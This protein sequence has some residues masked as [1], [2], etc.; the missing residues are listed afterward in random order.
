MIHPLETER[1]RLLPWGTDDWRELQ[2]IA[3]DREV[4]RYISNGQPW[5]DERIRELVDRQIA[6]FAQRG[7]CLWRLLHKAGGQMVGFCGLQPLAGTGE[8]EIG[9]WLGRAWWA[10]GLATEAARATMS[11]GFSR[12]G[13]ERIVAIAQPENRASLHVMEKL[14]MTFESETTHRGFRVVLCAITRLA[15]ERSLPD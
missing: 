11:D 6:G 12:V 15:W 10:Q 8:I 14:G 5:T 1:L 7:F 9:W 4:M 2:P 13:L 3:Q